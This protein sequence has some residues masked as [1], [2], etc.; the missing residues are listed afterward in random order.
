MAAW[1]PRTSP[2][3]R[4]DQYRSVQQAVHAP[5]TAMCSGASPAR[6]IQC[7]LMAL[8]STCHFPSWA[9]RC[10]Y[11]STSAQSRP[12]GCGYVC[13]RFK[14]APGD[15]G[16]D[17]GADV[18]CFGAVQALHGGD[19]FGGDAQGG[20]APTRVGCADTAC[21]GVKI[22]RGGCSRR[23][24]SS[25]SNRVRWSPGRRPRNPADAGALPGIPVR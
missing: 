10:R 21:H 4:C 17:G 7:R 9:L 1:L 2:M 8:R 11:G 3:R 13:I 6:S 5:L 24:R 18:F 22:E 12:H 15:A 23:K 19:G 25:A 14:A 20:A 16:T